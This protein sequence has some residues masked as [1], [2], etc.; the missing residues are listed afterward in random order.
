MCSSEI[1]PLQCIEYL[2]WKLK[3]LLH[4]RVHPALQSTQDKMQTVIFQPRRQM[5]M[6]MIQMWDNATMRG[7]TNWQNG[8]GN[9][10]W[11]VIDFLFLSEG[12]LFFCWLFVTE[13]ILLIPC[14]LSL[15]G[16]PVSFP[17]TVVGSFLA[18][19]D[20]IMQSAVSDNRHSKDSNLI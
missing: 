2:P 5:S 11:E 16:N 15:Y 6:E 1:N 13:V 4:A 14:F 19:L 9:L 17:V 20:C 7:L 10:M 8:I 3:H 12:S 18:V